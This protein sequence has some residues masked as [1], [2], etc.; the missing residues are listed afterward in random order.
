M[1]FIHATDWKDGATSLSRRLLQALSD[2]KRV[3]WLTSGGS[4]TIISVGIM[5]SISAELSRQL[6]IM[7]VDERYGKVG[8]SNSNW[9]QLMH[10]GLK[11]KAARTLPVLQPGLSFEETV[12]YYEQMATRAFDDADTV[13]AQLGIG[14]DGHI[15]GILPNSE[16]TKEQTAL[17]VGYQGQPY[18]RLTLTF[19]ALKRVTTLYVFAFG[20]NKHQALLSFKRDN[21]ALDEQPA[22][23]LKQLP[24]VYVYNDQIEENT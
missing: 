18:D 16:A 2:G 1:Q 8:H 9:A 14:Q 11:P 15:A 5:D 19:P 20:A 4:N 12:Q 13:I 17:V 7:P 21:L 22:Q 6:S 23:I 10:A 3:L 24:E